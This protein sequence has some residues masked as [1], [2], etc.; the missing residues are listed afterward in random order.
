MSSIVGRLHGVLDLDAKGFDAGL[1]A[2]DISLDGFVSKLRGVEESIRNIGLGLTAG[3]TLPV[4]AISIASARTAGDFEASMNRVK[5]AL[6]GIRPDQLSAL[7]DAAQEMGPAV[8]KSAI[9]AAD[10]IEMLAKNGLTASQIMDGA[11]EESLKLSALSFSDLG[12]S[13]DLVTDIMAQFGKSADELSP[14]V[15]RIAGALNASKFGF[16]DYAGAVAQVGGVAGGLGVSFED[17]NVALT[18]TSSLFASGSDAGT[19]FKTFLLALTP[20]SKEAGKEMERLGLSFFDASGQMKPLTEIAQILRDRLAGL[21]DEARTDALKTIFGTD[22][23]RTA[24]GLMTQGAAGLDAIKV[25][26]DQV[27]AAEQVA[28]ARDGYN[29][30]LK[31][32][33]SAFEALRI[34]IA[35]GGLLQILT[36]VNNAIAG[37]VDALADLPEPIMAA[38]G[39]FAGI[40]A[41]IGPLMLVM[42]TL[43]KVVI[44]LVALRFGGLG[45]VIGA[46]LNPIGL[47]ISALGSLIIRIGAARI[48]MLAFGTALRFAAGPIGLII[49]ALAALVLWQ[50]RST[51]ASEAA[52]IAQDKA[53]EGLLRQR[54]LTDQLAM[55]TGK[56][57]EELL[58]KARVEM[59]TAGADLVK[60]R[61][62]LGTAR[63]ALA[64]AKNTPRQS[65]SS[66]AR[67][68]YV[69]DDPN[70][71]KDIERAEN[72]VRARAQALATIA[73][74]RK[75]YA[76]AIMA[77]AYTPPEIPAA[78]EDDGKKTDTPAGPSGRSAEDI[79]ADYQNQLRSLVA[80]T[81]SARASMATSAQARAEIQHRMLNDEIRDRRDEITSNGDLTKARKAKLLEELSYLE[82][83]AR[84]RIDAE[85][86][87]RLIDEE[88]AI[89]SDA[90]NAQRESLQARESLATTDAERARIQMDILDKDIE[91]ERLALEGVLRKSTTNDTERLLAQKNL[92]L[93][94][95]KK[96]EEQ[97]IIAR[98]NAG[99][100]EAWRQAIPKS[101]AEINEAYENIAARGLTNMNDAL[102]EA[103]ARTLKLKGFAGQLFNQLISDLI[104]FQVQ[105]TMGGG[106]GILGGIFKLGSSL[107]G[108]GS[109]AALGEAIDID[110]LRGL[111]AIEAG[112][113]PGFDMGGSFRVAGLPGIDSNMMAINGVPVARVGQGERVI[114]DPQKG[115][116]DNGG[117]TLHI[118]PSDYFDVVVDKRAASVA[119]PMAVNSSLHARSAASADSVRRARRRIPGR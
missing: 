90:L 34:S 101:A 27:S 77:P 38:I 35:N 11:L 86:Q 18:A 10:G 45:L 15:N 97:A 46:L 23:I 68:G 66:V 16:D 6:Y 39:V 17:L 83:A 7:S 57:R 48:A 98:R 113:T 33:A 89:K 118:V 64:D 116:N 21:S 20:N 82:V 29:A 69:A 94:D 61:Q 42:L 5:S 30:S 112:S 40:A 2:A 50:G 119:G 103:A 26:I 100:L 47:I 93:L 87:D 81:L 80:Q 8:G 60:A 41:A 96:G 107:L 54:Q 104:R 4:A 115:Q 102:G 88:I 37:V 12:N 109:G 36:A 110:G 1:A 95:Q 108:G 43:A 70:V 3:I 51:E 74:R 49:T 92:D 106:G 65:G 58:A 91:M 78:V 117:G 99:P 25:A 75:A 73:D 71:A 9:E 13:A 31:D 24:I 32:K 63:K 55:A 111:A 67:F 79:D 62:D 76:D 114:V 59:N 56:L 72:E 22:A 84:Q 52:R 14:V 105:Q 85:A 28:T 53:S 44:P 19:S